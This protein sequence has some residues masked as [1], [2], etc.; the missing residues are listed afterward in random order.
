MATLLVIPALTWIGDEDEMLVPADL[1]AALSRYDRG[2]IG[3]AFEDTDEMAIITPELIM[4]T[5]YTG[6]GL[7]AIV[8]AASEKATS[9]NFVWNVYVEAKTPD[10]DTFDMETADGFDSK[11]VGIMAMAATAGNPMDLSILLTNDDS[12]TA[13]DIVR[14]GLRRG[15]TDVSDQA[16]DDAIFFLMEIADDA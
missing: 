5:P 3:Y 10:V 15:T 16:T 13:G 1:P 8:H 2:R 9:S 12:V 14:F 7:V 4:P 11:N 6:S